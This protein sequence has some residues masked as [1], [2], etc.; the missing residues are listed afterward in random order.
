MSVL[1]TSGAAAATGLAMP[2]SSLWRSPGGRWSGRGPVTTAVLR[3]RRSLAALRNR[4]FR[5]GGNGGEPPP[6]P[7]PNAMDF[8]DDPALWMLMIH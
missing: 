4:L 1:S 6:E 5:R 7:A 8:W 2:F 3:V